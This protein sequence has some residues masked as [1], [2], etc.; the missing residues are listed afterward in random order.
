MAEEVEGTGA[1]I[2]GFVE[3]TFGA[4]VPESQESTELKHDELNLFDAT[5]VAVSSVAPAYSLATALGSMFIISAVGFK[6]P[7]MVI[8]SFIPI[9]FIAYAY[10][11]LNRR[12]PN[13]GAS[14][15]WL[16]QVFHPGMGWF[17]GFIQAGI[18]TIFCIQSPIVASTY[19]LSFFAS[20][21]WISQ[22]TTN[23]R[24]LL[25][26]LGLFWLAIIT[27]FCIVGIRWT[28]NFQWILCII[29]YLVVV[30]MSI[31]G[32]IK[33]AVD[34]SARHAHFSAAWL[35]PLGVHSLGAMATALAIGT[36]LFWGWDTAV[37]LNEESKNASRTPGRAA[38]ISMWLI[39]AV[40]LLN[41]IAAEILLPTS[42]F[43][44]SNVLFVFGEAFAGKWAG[45]LMIFAVLSSSV[46]TT[47]TTLLPAAR[48]TYA[49]SRDGVFPKAF[50]RIHPKFRTPAVGT[51]ILGCIAAAGIVIVQYTSAGQNIIATFTNN[52]GALVAFY[53]G[54]TGVA[55]GW[56]F[57]KA[58]KEKTGFTITG[59]ILPTISGIVLIAIMIWDIKSNGWSGMKWDII[60]LIIAAVLTPIVAFRKRDT[61]YFKA[62]TISYDTIE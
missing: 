51:A 21:G 1:T 42:S 37:N 15:S 54:I 35:N 23:S 5:A 26:I 30:G 59:I 50:G 43:S 61:S 10:F 22:S 41:F 44:A 27:I 49:M 20:I 18:S 31:G 60:L 57:R 29:E 12:N 13:C 45:Y 36:F 9:L 38:I 40:F 24:G 3:G 6:A 14:Y 48:I 19:T 16:A 28:T 56:A 32:I 8:L 39:L 33:V 53:Y 2:G 7:G 25:M 17:N 34:P 11:H 62:K 52:V 58:W 47:Q 55:C 46:A 4:P